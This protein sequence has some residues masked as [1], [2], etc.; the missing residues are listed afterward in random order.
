MSLAAH[1]SPFDFGILQP[2]RWWNKSIFC[3]LAVSCGHLGVTCMYLVHTPSWAVNAN[4]SCPLPQPLLRTELH[5]DSQSTAIFTW[6]WTI[7][8]KSVPQKAQLFLAQHWPFCSSLSLSHSVPGDAQPA[9]GS[10]YTPLV[11]TRSFLT[12]SLD[13]K[14]FLQFLGLL[15]VPSEWQE[16]FKALLAQFIQVLSSSCLP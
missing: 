1:V 13:L 14:S 6:H 8:V 16:D 4:H 12:L 7:F 11:K 3:T 15:L 9:P 10:T 5:P 2:L